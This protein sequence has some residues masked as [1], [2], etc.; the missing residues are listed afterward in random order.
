[1]PPLRQSILC[2]MRCLSLGPGRR[3]GWLTLASMALVTGS[4]ACTTTQTD[5]REGPPRVTAPDDPFSQAVPNAP[6]G[7]DQ[8]TAQD[9]DRASDP[10]EPDTPEALGSMAQPI[11]ADDT[12]GQRAYLQ[13][14]RTPTGQRPSFQR[15]GTFAR[16]PYGNFLDGYE[17]TDPTT[18][19]RM[20]IYMDLYHPGYVESRAV[21]GFAIDPPSQQAQR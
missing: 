14:L 6:S 21:P 4:P 20:V 18:G 3:I 15:V 2:T 5:T 9:P 10:L 12:A 7:Q 19:H 8:A 13:R 17:L 11:R 1:M 16:G